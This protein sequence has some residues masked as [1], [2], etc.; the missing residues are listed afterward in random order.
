MSRLSVRLFG[1]L[2]VRC[3]EQVVCGLNAGKVQELFCYLLLHRDRPHPREAL[4]S[5]L[6][7]DTS[8]SQSKKYLRQSLWQLQGALTVHHA[9]LDKRPL[10]VEAE[11]V[12]LNSTSDLLLDVA[13]FEEAFAAVRHVPIQELDAARV[14]PLSRAADQ[15]QGNLLEGWYQDW[16]V[17][18]RERLQSMYLTMLDKLMGYSELRHEYETGITHGTRILRYDRARECTHQRLMRL[19]YLLGDRAAALRQYERC[20]AALDEELSVQPAEGTVALYEDIRLG[21]LACTPGANFGGHPAS[22]PLVDVLS[23][24]KKL[25]TALADLQQQVRENI[26]LVG[27]LLSGQRRPLQQALGGGQ[28]TMVRRASNT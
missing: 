2:S 16:C 24:L 5:L 8:T 20:V 28:A 22:A 4:A 18:E 1:R 3:D 27:G 14:Q 21:R 25:E 19:Y 26:G 7:G 6:W 12:Q 17:Y 15:Y 9:P 10:R 11:W 13:L 23:R